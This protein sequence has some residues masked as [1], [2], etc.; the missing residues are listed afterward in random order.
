MKLIQ[1]LASILFVIGLPL[2]LVTTNV[3][4]AAGEVALYERGFREYD[5]AEVTGVPLPELDRAAREI[6]HY[7]ENDASTLRIV[8]DRGGEEVSLFNERETEHM[9]D[10]KDLMQGVFRVHEIAL[11][12]VL[13][14]VVARFLWAGES[15]LRTLAKESM[16]G[17]GLGVIV[18]GAI[19][20][21]ALA[22]FD[23]AW[24]RFHEI[25]FTDDLLAAG[26]ELRP[27]H[28]DVS[29]PFWEDMT[30]L[31]GAA[32]IAQAALVMVL[33]SGYLLATRKSARSTDEDQQPAAA[34]TSAVNPQS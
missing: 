1:R 20:A 2:L 32:T 26:P 31:V 5:A 8:V 12:F 21:F 9:R 16:L 4:V 27:A 34:E 23:E 28:P 7:F 33:S 25:A 14:Y 6:V 10:V 30:Y 24:T 17:I 19:G 11:A 3:R 29:Q 13:S 22:G 15:S 18:V